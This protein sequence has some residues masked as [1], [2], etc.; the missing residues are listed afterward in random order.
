MS[1]FWLHH[2]LPEV[3]FGLPNPL[4]VIARFLAKAAGMRSQ[5]PN[6]QLQS[7]VSGMPTPSISL[8]DSP[9]YLCS[10]YVIAGSAQALPLYRIEGS[11]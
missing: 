10:L 2:Q 5:I 6:F 7:N 3:E 8:V 9:F 4:D 11:S 1:E